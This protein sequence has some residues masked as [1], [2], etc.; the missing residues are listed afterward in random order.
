MPDVGHPVD[1]RIRRIFA[2]RI[3]MFEN[4]QQLYVF[5]VINRVTLFDTQC[6]FRLT[7]M[8]LAGVLHS[9]TVGCGRLRAEIVVTVSTVAGARRRH[10]QRPELNDSAHFHAR[11]VNQRNTVVFHITRTMF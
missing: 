3:R 1:I 4:Y 6:Q 7:T 5:Q 2:R 11:Y 8:R 9:Q 10:C